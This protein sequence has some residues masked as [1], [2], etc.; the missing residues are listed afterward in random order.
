MKRRTPAPPEGGKC[1]SGRRRVPRGSVSAMQADAVLFRSGWDRLDLALL[2][3]DHRP[4]GGQPL[5]D[6]RRAAARGDGIG[7][8]A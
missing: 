4:L 3:F 1:F 5:S 8:L 2:R 6:S 7:R